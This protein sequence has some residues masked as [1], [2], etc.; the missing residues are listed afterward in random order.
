MMEK[1]AV[2]EHARENHHH[3]NWE[4]TTVLDRVRGQGK[5]QLKEALHME[6]TPAEECFNQDRGL[7]IP[8][9]ELH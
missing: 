8:V 2:A 7:E 1:L 9:A 4:E 6:M 3:I 5:L